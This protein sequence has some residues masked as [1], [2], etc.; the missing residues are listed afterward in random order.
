MINVKIDYKGKTAIIEVKGHAGYDKSGK[1]IVCAA[2]STAL[3]LTA[4]LYKKMNLKENVL[5]LVCDEAYF[6]LNVSISNFE[7]RVLF[8]NLVDTLDELKK[9]YPQY[10][11]YN[12]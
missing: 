3:I 11:K 4:N 10:I 8:E 5:D 1:D 2:V 12:N 9:D 7:A 6:L